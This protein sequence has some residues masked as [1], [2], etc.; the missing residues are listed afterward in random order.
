MKES[1]SAVFEAYVEKYSFLSPLREEILRAVE[2]IRET[3]QQRGKM[4]VCGN[5][6]SNA[7]A[8]HIVG[9]LVKG[10]LK[11]RTVSQETAELLSAYGEDGVV[12]AQMT[13][14]SLP[15]INLGAQTS[16]ITAVINDL[17]GPYIFSQQVMGLGAAGDILFAISTSGNS[18]NVVNAIMIAR[19]RGMKVIGL[20]GE[21][22]GRM[23]DICD[24]CIRVPSSFTPDIQ[25][26]HTSVYHLIC[27][28]VESE[29]WDE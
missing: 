20:T 16:L 6:G 22:G 13:Q 15:A 8:D 11:R 21:A 4:L 5:G 3:Y 17:G 2:L 19:T 12:L 25:D 9:E 7:D 14:G 1:T 10:F 23:K 18:K 27:A 28:A 24:C 26:M 29:F